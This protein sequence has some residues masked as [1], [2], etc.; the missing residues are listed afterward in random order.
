VRKGIFITLEGPEGSGKSTHLRL[1]GDYLRR[2]RLRVTMT[3]EPGG[4]ELGQ[5]LRRLLLRPGHGWTALAELFLYEADRAQHVERCIQPALAKGAI[6]L[7]DR[8]TDSTMAYQSAGRGL[9]AAAIR[10]LNRVAAQ[11]LVPDL[12]ILLDTPVKQGLERAR[13]KK[14]RADRLE[15]AGAAFHH[16]VRRSFL[17]L[18]RENPR[19]FKIVAQ[20]RKIEE[21]QR[22]IRDAVE[23]YLKR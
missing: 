6:V 10:A 9:P 21:T 13:R 17:K 18:A 3:R 14:G 1:L 8:F 7:C 16:R 22:R 12:T 15:R 2:R 19:R 23:A 11:R 5:M 20:Q 4:T